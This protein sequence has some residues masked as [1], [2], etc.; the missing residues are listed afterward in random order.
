[1]KEIGFNLDA[2]DAT[3]EAFLKYLIKESVGV[4]VQTPTEKKIVAQYPKK[5]IPFPQQLSFRFDED[6]KQN[7]VKIKRTHKA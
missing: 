1:M 4:S 7:E 5:I 6:D 2:P 3:K